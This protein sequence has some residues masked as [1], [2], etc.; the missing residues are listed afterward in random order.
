[1]QYSNIKKAF[2]LIESFLGRGL[3]AS[4]PSPVGS[5]LCTEGRR[6]MLWEP[7]RTGSSC[8]CQG[9]LDLHLY[10]CP[11]LLSPQKS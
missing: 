2:V 9:I 7:V 11:P 3:D 5:P 1:M 10:K 4:E 6:I 8:D